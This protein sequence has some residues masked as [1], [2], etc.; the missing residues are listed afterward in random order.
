MHEIKVRLTSGDEAVFLSPTPCPA[1]LDELQ[2]EGRLLA[3]K[4]GSFGWRRACGAVDTDEAIRLGLDLLEDIPVTIDLSDP[5]LTAST[6]K[7]G[8]RP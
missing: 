8:P 2:A 3:S 4:I 5:S 6:G 1:G 7:K